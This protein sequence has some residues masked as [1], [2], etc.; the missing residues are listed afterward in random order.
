MA[1]T[2][3]VPCQLAREQSQTCLIY[4]CYRRSQN[5]EHQLAQCM[6]AMSLC[7]VTP[8]L[9]AACLSFGYK[10]PLSICHM[11]Q[12]FTMAASVVSSPLPIY[13]KVIY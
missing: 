4:Y 11:L 7:C 3:A 9:A 5:G 13:I 2:L 8:M 1:S 12:Y 10:N 6:E